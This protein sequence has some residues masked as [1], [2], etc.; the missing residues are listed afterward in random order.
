MRERERERERSSVA[1]I[2]D[3]QVIQGAKMHQTGCINSHWLITMPGGRMVEG[4]EDY[5]AICAVPAD[6]PNLTYVAPHT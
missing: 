6:H 2:L 4:D 3:A 1:R 5:A